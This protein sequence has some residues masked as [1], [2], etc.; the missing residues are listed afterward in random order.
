MAKKKRDN[1]G[2]NE[3]K[4]TL[5]EAFLGFRFQI[6]ETAIEKSTNELKQLEEMNARYRE[7]NEQL[8]KEQKEHIKNLFKL[9]KEQDRELEHKE[10]IS[11]EQVEQTMRENIELIRQNEQQVQDIMT[12]TASVEQDILKAT[13]VKEYWL[14]YK[15]IG[16]VE[17]GKII[18]HRENELLEMVRSFSEM[19]DHFHRALERVKEETDKLAKEQMDEKKANATQKAISYMGRH[20]RQEVKE[21]EWLK[22]ELK[23]YSM[24]VANIEQAVQKVEEENLEILSQLFD[25]QI[26]DLNVCRNL[27]EICAVGPKDHD[28]SLLEGNSAELDHRGETSE[29]NDINSNLLKPKCKTLLPVEK[30]VSSMFLREEQAENEETQFQLSKS[31][32]QN[33]TYLL[34]DDE[35][36]LEVHKYGEPAGPISCACVRLYCSKATWNFVGS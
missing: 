26:S 3:D 20:S 8:K 28:A 36:F 32:S 9:A 33:L 11:T 23:Q 17:H 10:L 12:Y 5:A 13:E 6:K 1:R 25:C 2:S 35:K 22:K 31:V 27:V 29:I 19:E 30:E 34:Q 18:E 16:S 24:E 15:N 7:R 21:N 14:E 4:M